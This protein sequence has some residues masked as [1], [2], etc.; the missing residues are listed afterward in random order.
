MVDPDP[1]W[2][3]GT[4]RLNYPRFT[5]GGLAMNR[6]QSE[7]TS[8]ARLRPGSPPG[9]V[10]SV[11]LTNGLSCLFRRH[12]QRVEGARGSDDVEAEASKIKIHR[13]N[14]RQPNLFHRLAKK[15]R[16]TTVLAALQTGESD[17]LS[18]KVTPP[19]IATFLDQLPHFG[20]VRG[21]FFR[22]PS[23]VVSQQLSP[24]SAR[25]ESRSP[26][27][28]VELDAVPLNQR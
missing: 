17:V 23:A 14:E 9:Y 18:A 16:P 2:F 19:H 11:V 1:R 12:A 8:R 27:L 5:T 3:F 26:Y 20:H 7:A 25:H 4:A 6:Q 22:V 24:C 21:S 15:V 10:P 28:L 13:R